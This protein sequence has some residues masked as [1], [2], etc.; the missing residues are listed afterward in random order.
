MR[1]LNPHALTSFPNKLFHIPNR[2]YCV[3]SEKMPKGFIDRF[4]WKFRK[5]ETVPYTKRSRYIIYPT[6]QRE[7]SRGEKQ[8]QL[9][10]QS[11]RRDAILP[12]SHPHTV[13]VTKILNNILNALQK[14]RNKMRSASD[15]SFLHLLWLR[16]IRRLPP[17]MSHLDGLNWEI[18]VVNA[19]DLTCQCC[20]GGKMIISK[21][22]INHF[23]NDAEI[24]TCIA[25]EVAHIVARH[26][27]EKITKSVWIYIVYMGLNKFI[28]IDYS[29]QVA[30][31]VS[32]LPFHRRFEIEADYIG[33][34][35]MAA[36]G[37]DP[38][39]APKVYEKIETLYERDNDSMLTC[40]FDTHPSGGKRA[41]ALTRPKIMNEALVLYNEAIATTRCGVE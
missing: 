17:S 38:Q 3:D 13:R 10:K 5:Y 22:L 32:R 18:L 28:S 35:L 33:L 7:R 27:A 11:F 12:P 31:L 39:V 4:K 20:P 6:H 26:P 40:F 16:L 30:P 19:P 21:V 15:Y 23:S 14:E 41:N 29:K 37:Y 9:F 8:F 36:A 2:F 25:H 1:N 34:L 24:A